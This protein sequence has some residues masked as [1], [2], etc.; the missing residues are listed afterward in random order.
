MCNKVTNERREEQQAF[1]MLI[2]SASV[3]LEL[4]VIYMLTTAKSEENRVEITDGR[5]VPSD[6]RRICH[7]LPGV[8]SDRQL[9]EVPPVTLSECD[10]VLVQ[11][12]QKGRPST[13]CVREIG[14][15][16]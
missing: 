12:E 3:Y 13:I 6:P 11:G 5:R 7:R 8:V 1:M 15:G 4:K 2:K 10:R 14:Q 9:V 16:Q